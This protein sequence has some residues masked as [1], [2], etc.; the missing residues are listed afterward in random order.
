MQT[1]SKK[2]QLVSVVFV[3]V[4]ALSGMAASSASAVLGDLSVISRNDG[5]T[6]LVGDE[7]SYANARSTSADGRYVV[8][9]SHATTFGGAPT[10][11]RS[12]YRRDTL[13]GRTELVSRADGV[14]GAPADDASFSASVS[15]D[16]NRVAFATGANNLSNDDNDTYTNIFL[17]DIAAGTTTL[18]S[19]ASNGGAANQSSLGARISGNGAFVA[20]GSTANNLDATVVDNNGFGDAFVRDIA[21]GTTRLVSKTTAGAIGNGL[22]GAGDISFDGRYVTVDSEANNLGGVTGG[23][24]QVYLRDRA[25]GT[26]TL[27]SQP[28]G[29]TNA[30]GNDSSSNSTITDS[31]DAVAFVSRASNLVPGTPPNLYLGIV[32]NVAANV[33]SIATRSTAGEV[34]NSDVSDPVMA[35]DGSGITYTSTATNLEGPA[36]TGAQ[37]FFTD[38]TT[39]Q[40]QLVSR[41]GRDGAAANAASSDATLGR[42]RNLVLFT[43][44][45]SNLVADATNGKYQL[46]ARDVRFVDPIPQVTLAGKRFT[47]KVRR[48]RFAVKFSTTNGP[49]AIAGTATIRVA[50]RI[51]RSGKIVVKYKLR[52]ISATRSSHKITFKL[53]KRQNK[54][55]LRALK[56]KRSRLKVTVALVAS[57]PGS[58]ATRRISGKLRR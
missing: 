5:P 39:G 52:A 1:F 42:T 20:F 22:S 36:G 23:N 3:V 30:G 53:S 12:I 34:A 40:T 11:A 7:Q 14:A 55:V 31:G 33:T 57:K 15:A 35:V 50:K 47:A 26:T 10:A 46:F 25:L 54:L 49:T 37:T 21:A 4:L 43:T 13:L 38:L 51:A 27:L 24:G 28:S 56:T 45:A 32:R 48:S 18:V 19:R 8:F 29:T 44:A 16:G 17:R 2:S 6:G 41:F 58:Q 9:I